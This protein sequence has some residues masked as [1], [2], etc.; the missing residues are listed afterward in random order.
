MEN[1]RLFSNRQKRERLKEEFEQRKLA[2]RLILEGYFFSLHDLRRYKLAFRCCRKASKKCRIRIYVSWEELEKAGHYLQ[3]GVRVA[4]E[5]KGR[6][7]YDLRGQHS[8]SCMAQNR[9]LKGVNRVSGLQ[10]LGT[11]ATETG[12]LVS[13]VEKN[14]RM[15]LDGGM[16]FMLQRSTVMELT[17]RRKATVL[18]LGSPYSLDC[19]VNS[20]RAYIVEHELKLKSKMVLTLVTF[21][22]EYEGFCV[23]GVH[24]LLEIKGTKSMREGMRMLQREIAKGSEDGEERVLKWDRLVVFSDKL[25]AREAARSLGQNVDMSEWDAE[26]E[27]QKRM[28]SL[29]V[30]QCPQIDIL[31]PLCRTLR[32]LGR[33]KGEGLY[34]KAVAQARKEGN[35]NCARLVEFFWDDELGQMEQAAAQSKKTVLP[36]C[37]RRFFES[38]RKELISKR[39]EMEVVFNILRYF[40]LHFRQKLMEKNYRLREKMMRR[41][42]LSRY[43]RREEMD[44]DNPIE[45][46]SQDFIEEDSEDEDL[47]KRQLIHKMKGIDVFVNVL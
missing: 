25:T 13:Q 1:R 14:L 2:K 43:F 41:N 10:N 19:L 22:A 18:L 24:L 12:F 46:E 35:E 45:I 5:I 40:E 4:P 27:V 17:W 38:L 8:K 16:A 15:T 21:V 34:H 36:Y 47:D 31:L 28:I 39:A 29:G 11:A 23:P 20:T 42:R 9:F 37:C 32:Q 30:D 7:D 44:E 26:W 6:I 3:G 33:A